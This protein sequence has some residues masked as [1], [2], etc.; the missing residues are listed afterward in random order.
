MH[1]CHPRTVCADGALPFLRASSGSGAGAGVDQ[2]S[3]TSLPPHAGGV[4]PAGDRRRP[5]RGTR[6]RV[7]QAQAGAERV[8]ALRADR[9]GQLCARPPARPHHADLQ[10]GQWLATTPAYVSPR[11]PTSSF[12]PPPPQRARST[13]RVCP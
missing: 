4:G 10:G 2:I 6:P 3:G 9:P 5:P 7:L 13:Y 8:G 12:A 11:R 1:H